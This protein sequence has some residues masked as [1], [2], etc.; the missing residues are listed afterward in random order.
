M[1]EVQ[2][3]SATLQDI[4]ELIE[5][6]SVAGE[7]GSRPA[8][9]PDLVVRLLQRDPDAVIVAELDGAIVGTI[10]CGWDGWRGSL[11]RL[12][13]SPALRRQGIGRRLLAAAEERLSSLGAER[14]H[15][16]VLDEN[17]S[18]QSVWKAAGYAPQHDWSRWVKPRS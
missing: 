9:R 15:A 10:I 17:E 5:F 4:E 12:A 18:G 1:P 13:V 14:F 16:M 7:N 11:Y 8:D 2:I 6:W 3:R